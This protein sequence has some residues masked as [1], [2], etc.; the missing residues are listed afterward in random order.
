MISTPGYCSCLFSDLIFFCLLTY[1]KKR[2][3]NK[4]GPCSLH[5]SPCTNNFQDSRLATWFLCS[6]FF[7]SFRFPEPNVIEHLRLADSLSL[8]VIQ[9]TPLEIVSIFLRQT[10]L[11]P[12]FYPYRP[13]SVYSLYLQKRPI[14]YIGLF[15]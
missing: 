15:I 7:F 10:Y 2:S 5:P 11:P 12:K 13:T 9:S 8:C 4:C 6:R 3:L 1:K 14:W